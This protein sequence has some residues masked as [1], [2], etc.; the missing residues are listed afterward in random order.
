MLGHTH[1][2]STPIGTN[3]STEPR[4]QQP[5]TVDNCFFRHNPRVSPPM[6]LSSFHANLANFCESSQVNISESNLMP[7]D[8]SRRC[9][10]SDAFF[11]VARPHCRGHQWQLI[12]KQ[13]WPLQFW[14]MGLKTNPKWAL[15][16]HTL[17]SQGRVLGWRARNLKCSS[18]L[19]ISP[20][21]VYGITPQQFIFR[22]EILRKFKNTK[23]LWPY[24]YQVT[25]PWAW[26]LRVQI[27]MANTQPRC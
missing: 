19:A 12:T 18:A 20:L 14:T 24:S 27:R 22:N 23:N 4:Y 21:S 7:K 15:P 6:S 2:Q 10:A 13:L 9:Q 8:I 17:K 16:P 11:L 25:T 26:R 1:R 5:I 3:V